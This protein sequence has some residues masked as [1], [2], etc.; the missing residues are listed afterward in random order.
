MKKIK[1]FLTG[2]C[3]LHWGRLEFG[4]IG[5]YY[6]MEPLI[7]GIHSISPKTEIYTTFQI[8]DRFCKEENVNVVPED[9]YYLWDA[10]NKEIVNQEI[11]YIKNIEKI[12][13]LRNK[14]KYIN[15]IMD[16]DLMIDFSGDI[17]GKNA[18]FLGTDRFYS[19]LIK[20]R[21][22]QTLGLPTVLLAGSPGPFDKETLD[23]AKT[24]YSQFSLVT[25]REP[26]ST[27]LLL[28]E[29]F[30]LQNTHD[31]VCPS[32]LFDP[33]DGK[34][35][36]LPRINEDSCK[37]GF[38]IC[39]WNFER[40]PFDAW[41][42]KDFEYDPFVRIIEHISDK[43]GADIYLFSHSNGFVVPPDNFK[44]IHGRDYPLLQQLKRI[45]D[46]RGVAKRV[47]LI[48]E[49]YTPWET[50]KFIGK[51]DMVISGRVHA[52]IAA[53][54]QNV[55]AV[56][57]DYGHEPKAHKL[58]GFSRI[59]GVEHLLS[60]V[61]DRKSFIDNIDLCWKNRFELREML[62][63]KMPLIKETAL[64]NFDIMRSLF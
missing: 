35:K 4:N 42:R 33:S 63:E 52:A 6:V 16:S 10:D 26:V 31:L 14:S 37:I 62:S 60:S 25:N 59:G 55:P 19:G 34:I 17:W 38:T 20:D 22:A 1:I 64:R 21:I 3:T 23:L 44:L 13:V 45:I 5:N 48:E 2:Q 46:Q 29:G 54:S 58:R 24:I 43:I 9:L 36:K 18:D 41:P 50:K 28:S 47:F 15:C 53:L 57:V 30:N 40:G 27:E 12:S 32:F 61:N 7:R 39:G 8:S 51:F 49:I 56:I 11:N